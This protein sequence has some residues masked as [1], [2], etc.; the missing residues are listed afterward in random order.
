[1]R[2][3]GMEFVWLFLIA[4]GCA[5]A[6]ATGN[7]DAMVTSVLDGIDGAVTLVIGLI[8]M[9]SLWVGIEGSPM[10]PG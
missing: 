10:K 1:M 3:E 2:G 6:V 7:V 9:F 8:G 4:T 5:V